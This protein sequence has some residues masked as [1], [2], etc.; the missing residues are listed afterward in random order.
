MFTLSRI[1]LC[2][3]AVGMC[4]PLLAND[5]V[6]AKISTESG[7]DFTP[8]LQSRLSHD[9]NIA[10]ANADEEASWILA[11]TPS[12]T[13]SLEEGANQYSATVSLAS[14]TYF[15]SSADNFLD[16]YADARAKVDLN[17]SNRF[18]TTVAYFSGHEARGTGVSEGLGNVQNEPTKFNTLNLN[19]FYEYGAISTPARVRAVAGYFDKEFTNFESVTQFR[20]SDTV[21]LGLLFFYDTQATTSLVFE[22]LQEETTY[23]VVDI[24]G[25]RDSTTMKYRLGVEWEATALT[26]GSLRVGLQDKNFDNAARKDFSGLTWQASITYAPLSYSQFQLSTGRQAKDPNLEGDFVKETLHSVNWLH[27]WTELLTTNLGVNYSHEAYTGADRTDTTKG[28]KVSAAY[29]LRSNIKLTSGVDIT[30]KTSSVE[31]IRFDKNV[32]FFD[33]QAGF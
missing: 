16:V 21:N 8:L 33:V 1:V 31:Q 7:I 2:T 25:S 5:F 29:L 19:G 10:S 9:D 26:S 27:G 6:P 30:R 28:V 13:A 32:I 18:Q 4:S 11:V 23:D 17:Q 22:V 14:G 12:L 15:S 3:A 20:N 24:T